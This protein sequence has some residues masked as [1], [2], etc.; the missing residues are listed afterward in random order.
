MDVL[1]A[2]VECLEAD[3]SCV[4]ISVEA[5]RAAK[6]TNG[7]K[8]ARGRASYVNIALTA[9][10]EDAG[11]RAVAT[12]VEAVCKTACVYNETRV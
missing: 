11:A 1:L 5:D 6:E 8:A 4:E 9:G 12:W 2:V 3:Q 7:M 10:K